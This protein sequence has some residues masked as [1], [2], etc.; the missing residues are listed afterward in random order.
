MN[1]E[2]FVG[3]LSGGFQA[4]FEWD[5]MLFTLGER[6]VN[7]QSIT[8]RL[9]IYLYT[10]FQGYNVD[11]EYNKAWNK[12]KA[13][14]RAGKQSMKPD[15]IVHIRNSDEANLFC[16][17]AKKY[18]D[19]DNPKT[20]YE[21]IKNKLI[22]LTH[23]EDIYRYNLGLAWKIAENPEPDAHEAFWFIHGE[24]VLETSLYRFEPILIKLLQKHHG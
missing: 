9:G 22:G 15:V 6:G 24:M 21:D 10:L 18:Y 23:P 7:E 14:E 3:L 4:L 1:A 20:G 12:P 8:F 11:C 16:L 19:W 13:S 5:S 17:E 2:R